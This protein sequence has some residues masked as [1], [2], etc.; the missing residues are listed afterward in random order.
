MCAAIVMMTL[1]SQECTATPL[2]PIATKR[3][4]PTEVGGFDN[5]MGVPV[6]WIDG[7]AQW[8]TDG[9][10]ANATLLP[11]GR[12][13][14]VFVM[15]GCGDSEYIFIGVYERRWLRNDGVDR[16]YW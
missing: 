5:Y 4:A 10:V 3:H 11:N 8:E 13:V 1:L 16:N 2:L 14:V 12:V 9:Y 7:Q 15:R 6:R